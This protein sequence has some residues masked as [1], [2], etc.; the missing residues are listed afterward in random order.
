MSDEKFCAVNV[1]IE[2]MKT[3]PEEFFEAGETRGR[4]TFMYKEYFKDSLTESEKGL[5][6]EALRTVRRLEFDAMV[7]KELLRDEQEAQNRVSTSYPTT[8]GTLVSGALGNLNVFS[9]GQKRK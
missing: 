6:H 1:L 8:E 5:I 7:F 9:S 4:W 2:R 3:H